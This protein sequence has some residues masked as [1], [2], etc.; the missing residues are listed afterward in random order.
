METQNQ[1]QSQAPQVGFP[2][3]QPRQKKSMNPIIIIIPVFLLIL[4]G[5]AYFVF[6][7]SS[8]EESSSSPTPAS[9]ELSTVVTP[10]PVPSPS[11]ST[12]P[13]DKG[14]LSLR[15]LNGTGIPGEAGYLQGILKNL[16]Y[17]KIDT[18]NADTSDATSTTIV[19]LS[20]VP[21]S[22]IDEMVTKLKT[23]YKSVNSRLASVKGSF[24]I[25]ITTG[26]RTGSATQTSSPAPTSTPT[27]GQ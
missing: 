7:G 2:T 21:Q 3:P 22:L 13:A 8:T 24:D 10:S 26:P 15:V 14:S 27:A 1:A 19:Y 6:K 17:T 4:G 23:V 18:G 5:L 11:P 12:S 25:E 9:R 20:S 16:G